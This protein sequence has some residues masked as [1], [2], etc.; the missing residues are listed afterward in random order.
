MSL[1]I[2]PFEGQAGSH[3]MYRDIKLHL[4]AESIDRGRYKD[5]LARIAEA[6]EW[7]ESLGVGK[8]YDDLIDTTLE[9]WLTAIV[10]KRLGS[11]SLSEEYL[12]KVKNSVLLDSFEEVTTKTNGSY[13]ELMSML[14]NLD[15]SSDKKLF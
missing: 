13:P 14:G 3:V 10:Y 8:P 12:S 9:N 2:L 4:A 11:D 5:A 6:Q 15:A 7:P 1:R